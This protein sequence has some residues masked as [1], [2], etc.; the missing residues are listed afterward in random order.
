M[1]FLGATTVFAVWTIGVTRGGFGGLVDPRFDGAVPDPR[2]APGQAAE[3]FALLTHPYLVVAVTGI[4][5]LRSWGDRQRRLAAALA[6]AALGILGADLLRFVIGRPRPV[7]A[8]HDSLSATGPGY[9]SGHLVA[10]TV[11]TWVLITLA[12]AQRKG[13]RSQWKRRIVGVFLVGCVGVDQWVLGVHHGSDLV[14]GMLLGITVAT[15]ALWLS[16]VEAI[17]QAWRLRALPATS[18]GLA[19]VIYNP[20]KITDL[21]LFHRRVSYAMA[22]AGWAAP[23]WL[24]TRVDDP[25]RDMARDALAKGVDRVIVAG[26]DGTVRAVCAELIGS[27]VPAA[28]LPAGTGNLWGRNLRVPLDEDQALEVALN[29]RAR[30]VDTVSWHTDDTDAAFMVMAGVGLDAQI[31]RDTNARLKRLARGGAYVVAGVQQVRMPPFHARVVVDGAV[32]HDGSAVMTL[33][34]NVGKLQG[35]LSLI[36]GA[37]ATDGRL[38]VLV[39]SG[40]GGVRGLLRLLAGIRRSGPTAPMRR[41]SGSRVEVTLDRPVA[42][43]LDGDIVG[44]TST[45]RAESNPRSLLVMVG[46]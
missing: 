46:R 24:E 37:E 45:L 13:V 25:G 36:P 41:V 6:I 43:Q 30:A 5:A 10:A 40:N 2:S 4:L 38:H 44:Q 20:T 17:T 26:G 31:M 39:A 33:V 23:L 15:G 14:G 1:V 42:Y 8:F 32:V 9:P 16:G 12:N 29:G 3:A 18:G 22:R 28:I 34:G 27:G 35:G 21:D 11:L 7:S 19:A